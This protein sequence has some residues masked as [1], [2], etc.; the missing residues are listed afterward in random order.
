MRRCSTNCMSIPPER[1]QDPFEKNVPGI[2]VGR[3]GARTPMQW[4]DGR[5][6]G[7]SAGEPW[8]PVGA[9]YATVNVAAQRADPASMLNLNRRLIAL[10]RAHPALSIGRYRRVLAEGDLL[11]YLREHAG[12]RLL[13]MLNLGAAPVPARLPDSAADG[14]IL[15]SSFADCD[16]EAVSRAVDL[17]GDEGLVIRLALR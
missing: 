1:V 6:A 16:G 10:R 13:T 14:R 8:L 3:D 11:A 5:H 2:G 7:F 4:D 17:R 15:L 9:D 12:E